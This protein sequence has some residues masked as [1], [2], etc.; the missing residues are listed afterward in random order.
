[1]HPGH[2]AHDLA[3]VRDTL[4]CVLRTV[5]L[6]KSDGN[7]ATQYLYDSELAIRLMASHRFVPGISTPLIDD[8]LLRDFI[9]C[10]QYMNIADY[11]TTGFHWPHFRKSY[12][13]SPLGNNEE[14]RQ[15]YLR[16]CGACLSLARFFFQTSRRDRTIANCALT[17]GSDSDHLGITNKLL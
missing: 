9:H 17:F 1:M 6:Q 12:L 15:G 14:Q 4:S 2:P 8:T 13:S 7:G 11:I 3:F 16:S 10:S 5:V